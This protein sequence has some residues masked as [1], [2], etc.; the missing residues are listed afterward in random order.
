MSVMNFDGW[1]EVD[2]ALES[3]A[4]VFRTYR[5]TKPFF[6]A[7]VGAVAQVG[8]SRDIMRKFLQQLRNDSL[9][10]A[11]AKWSAHTADQKQ[12]KEKEDIVY[13]R[14]KFFNQLQCLKLWRKEAA[15][16]VCIRKQM[17]SIGFRI[18]NAGLN[19]C[20]LTWSFNVY[21]AVKQRSIMKRFVALMTKGAMDECFA[22]W[23][24][25]TMH[26]VETRKMESIMRKPP[27]W[28]PPRL[29]YNY[30]LT[31]RLMTSCSVCLTAR[32]YGLATSSDDANAPPSNGHAQLDFRIG[33]FTHLG[34]TMQ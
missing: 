15:S 29:Q 9:G 30:N 33:T 31:L 2:P 24:A 34:L 20:F 7:W 26:S 10:L 18:M 14:F 8:R 22:A 6:A 12:N 28:K 19:V 1:W 4:M 27:F 13:K 16:Q 23:S 11:F 25:L 32:L 17:R 5:Q 21:V 3:R